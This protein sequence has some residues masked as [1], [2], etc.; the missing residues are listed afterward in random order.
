MQ[1]ADSPGRLRDL[2]PIK[3]TM[4]R[5]LHIDGQASDTASGADDV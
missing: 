4:G 3:T 5:V 2:T 1:G